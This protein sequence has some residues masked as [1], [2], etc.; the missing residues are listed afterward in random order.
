M[1]AAV[2][3]RVQHVDVAGFMPRPSRRAA[4][5]D[6]G[7]DALAHRAQMHRHVRRVGDQRAVAVEQ[8]AGE[9]E[10]LLDVDGIGGVLQRDAHLLGD[11]HEE[12]VEDLEHHRIDRWCRR[13]RGRGSGTDALQHE[14]APPVE[15]RAPAR[16]D[17][18]GRGR[19][20]DDR[21]AVDR[22]R[23]ARSASRSIDRRLDAPRPR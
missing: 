4:R 18:G 19:L 23:R 17:H 16:L 14:I 12:V 7:L 5:A 3:G 15:Q 9:I 11:R 10:P 6:D 1:R 20:A 21:R 22:A 8:R 2:V 13:R